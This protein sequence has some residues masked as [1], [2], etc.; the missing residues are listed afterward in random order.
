MKQTNNI[1]QLS[2]SNQGFFDMTKEEENIEAIKKQETWGASKGM[3]QI[4]SLLSYS[5]QKHEI[6]MKT[7]K[8]YREWHYT[9]LPS[10]GIQQQTSFI[11]QK[12]SKNYPMHE[13]SV[14]SKLV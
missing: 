3:F 7:K 13:T 5:K 1:L 2:K 9:I 10:Q 4:Y 8:H 12:H 11:I 6:W 14:S